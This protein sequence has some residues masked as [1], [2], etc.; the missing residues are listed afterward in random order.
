MLR[1]LR[2]PALP[3]A[4]LWLR[5]SSCRITYKDK[6]GNEQTVKAKEG[7]NL[8]DLAHANDIDLEGACGGAIACSTCHLVVEPKFFAMLPPPSEEEL[9]MLDLAAGLTKTSR[10]GCQVIVKKEL[11][12][13]AVTLPSETADARGVV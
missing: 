1:L 13:M 10:L 3:S 7:D 12:G 2:P 8:L 11:D 9:D 5:R 4:A 6:D